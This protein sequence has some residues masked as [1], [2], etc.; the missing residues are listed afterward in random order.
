M[1]SIIQNVIN[2]RAKYISS[3]IEIIHRVQCTCNE[4]A[5]IRKRYSFVG[6]TITAHL[7][8]KRDVGER[9]GRRGKRREIGERRKRLPQL[10]N[11]KDGDGSKLRDISAHLFA[12]SRPFACT[13]K[14]RKWATALYFLLFA[15]H[16]HILFSPSPVPL[17][18][19]ARGKW[20]Q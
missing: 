7:S 6:R 2:K 13:S 11:R 4:S 5:R 1:E 15:L 3:A 18:A 20:N 9:T 8:G 14:Q 10:G 17:S 16:C 19:I 12:D